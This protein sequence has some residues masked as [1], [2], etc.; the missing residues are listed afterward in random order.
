MEP[1]HS[2][3]AH[4]TIAVTAA[5]ASDHPTPLLVGDH[6]LVWTASGIG[7]AACADHRQII[8]PRIGMWVPAGQPVTASDDADVI[9]ASFEID[10]WGSLPASPTA[11]ELDDLL[12]A[13]LNEYGR[14]APGA[15]SDAACVII[16]DRLR[17]SMKQPRSTPPMPTDPSARR[18]AEAIRADPSDR[19]GLSF[20]AREVAMSE[21][22]LRRR[23]V[24]ETGL[25][26]SAWTSAVRI[27]FAAA[28]ISEGQPS[29]FVAARC[30]YRSV[31]ALRRALDDRTATD[32]AVERQRRRAR[33][34][35][36]VVDALGRRVSVPVAPQRIAALHHFTIADPLLDLGAPVVA[37]T[38]DGDEPTGPFPSK[39]DITRLPSVGTTDRPDMQALREIEP[40]LIV[41]YAFQGCGWADVEELQRI[42]PTVAIDEALPRR[43]TLEDL[44]SFV[45][46]VDELEYARSE[47][48]SS[49]L[50]L[51][52]RLTSRRG[53]H[54]FASIVVSGGRLHV[55]T[56]LNP[57]PI[58]CAIRDL[59]LCGVDSAE[60]PELYA[61]VPSAHHLVA[62]GQPDVLLVESRSDA[63][64]TVMGWAQLDAVV[65]D[66]VFHIDSPAGISYR[67]SQRTLA[68]VEAVLDRLYDPSH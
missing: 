66:R 21:R 33:Q 55:H 26:F 57:N 53:R 47:Y 62:S 10:R 63:A 60:R 19:R 6:R 4:E 61:E 30:G 25:T 1:V 9:I 14:M 5:G 54:S 52:R 16:A 64:D 39:H 42:A 44:A 15:V 40:D 7:R 58:A 35:R 28:L 27:E 67:S 34:T 24:D 23:F 51:R 17:A 2:D 29:G 46:R 49:V 13:M 45:G 31:K 59:G 32:R 65:A 48:D 12:V 43:R 20:W 37:I 56:R 36:V 41:T 18:V 38:D 68:E 22:T 3:G 50:D 11:V 8:T